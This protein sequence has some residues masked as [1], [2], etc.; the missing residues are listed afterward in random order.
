MSPLELAHAALF[1]VSFVISLFVLAIVA[2]IL[3]AV[4]FAFGRRAPD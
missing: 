2:L 1:A 4:M 3:E